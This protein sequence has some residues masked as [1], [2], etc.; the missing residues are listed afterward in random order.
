MFE[1]IFLSRVSVPSK[2]SEYG[3]VKESGNYVYHAEIR[4]GE[5]SLAVVIGPNG[6]IDTVLTEKETDEEYVLYKSDSAFG[7][8]VGQIREEISEILR[9]I[10]AKCFE[11]SVYKAPQTLRIIDHVYETYGDELEFLWTKFPDNAVWRRKDTGKWYGALMT[12]PR[13]RLGL[14]SDDTVEII[15]LRAE[16]GEMEDLLKKEN[17]YP[18]WHMNKK[19]W[20]TLTLDDRLGD[21]EIE[22]RIRIS[23]ALAVK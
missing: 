22:E 11:F 7:S 1:D 20:L 4:N 13:N 3:F 23:H 18:G 19:S 14:D 2:L 9:D 21:D 6:K 12:V 15:D 8:Y 16:P 17:Y 10:S 5:F